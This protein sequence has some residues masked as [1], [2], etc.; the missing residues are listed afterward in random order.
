[1]PFVKRNELGAIVAV[2]H[3][4]HSGFEEE[5]SSGNPDLA[6]FLNSVDG[7]ESAL[8][9]TDQDFVRVLEDVV[10]LLI[11]KGVILFTDLPDYCPGEDHAA[12]SSCVVSWVGGWI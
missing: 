5:V 3:D 8:S 10:Q 6:G 2:S 9:A 12:A 1:M 11:D 4:S 7:G